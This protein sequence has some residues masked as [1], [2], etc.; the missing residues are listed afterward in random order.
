MREPL[1]IKILQILNKTELI[2]ADLIDRILTPGGGS[3]GGFTSDQWREFR[4]RSYQ[5][6]CRT[7]SQSVAIKELGKIYSTIYHLKK[8]GLVKSDTKNS[9]LRLTKKGVG[10]LKNIKN[11][12]FRKYGAKPSTN[13]AIVIFDISEKEKHKRAWL[14]DVLKNIG[15]IMLQ[16]SVWIGKK[17]LPEDFIQ[18][19]GELKL[20]D[21]VKIF[22][23]HQMG[24]IELNINLDNF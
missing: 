12:L 22:S 19:L 7:A 14:R 11:T 17:E 9:T 24:N 2:T 16:K 15:F 18:D 20:L 3:K 10:R 23:V 13:L 8:S 5:R 21:C 4:K 1:T 6:R